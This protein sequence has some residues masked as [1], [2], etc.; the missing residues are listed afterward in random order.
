MWGEGKGQGRGRTWST[1]GS[2]TVGG[3]GADNFRLLGA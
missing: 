2:I 3:K 1:K